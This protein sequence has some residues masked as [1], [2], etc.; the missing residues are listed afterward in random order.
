[1]VA[2]L[3]N[4]V[5][6]LGLA[7]ADV[8]LDLVLRNKHVMNSQL[9]GIFKKYTNPLDIKK[10][11]RQRNEIIHRGRVKDEEVETFYENQN[12]LHAKR[13][14]ILN[15]NKISEEEYKQETAKQT[16]ML[17]DLASR[18]QAAYEAHYKTTLEM[19]A[20]VLSSL[21]RKATELSKTR[22]T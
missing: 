1:M 17:L 12:V 11:K 20:E 15:T 3:I 9:P 16:R 6:D 10:M 4:K 19:V 18:K 22:T 2:A 8:K 7:D 14:S 5:F 13:Y 21:G